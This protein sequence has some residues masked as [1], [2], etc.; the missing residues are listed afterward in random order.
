VTHER[1]DYQSAQHIGG[2]HCCFRF[3]IP[4]HELAK[5]KDA[6]FPWKGAFYRI[7]DGSQSLTDSND[8]TT[9]EECQQWA[10]D[11]A[12]YYDFQESEYDYSCGTGCTYDEDTIVFGERTKTYNCTELTK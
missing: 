7:V 8:F 5:K 6:E 12:E 3:I 4:W 9:L 1:Q 2:H 10:V 11:R